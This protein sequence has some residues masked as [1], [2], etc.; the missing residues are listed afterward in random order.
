MCSGFKSLKKGC[1]AR[2]GS[3]VCTVLLL[4][5]PRHRR[6][7]LA[8]GAD[9]FRNVDAHGTPG[10]PPPTADAARC[11]ELVDPGG[12]L[13]RQPLTVP[14]RGGGA[15]A[16]AVDIREFQRE[17]G[18]PAAPSPRMVAG[19]IGQVVHGGAEAGR[20]DHG[21]VTAGQAPR[22]DL[23]PARVLPVAVE[24][25]LDIAGVQTPPHLRRSL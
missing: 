12:E 2:T 1:A 22:G 3:S 11:A 20:A 9:F 5:C 24:E 6:R 7:G 21:A 18:A 15:D 4:P 16:P 14:G 19:E 23:L 8:D 25:F 10:N 17:A 13:V